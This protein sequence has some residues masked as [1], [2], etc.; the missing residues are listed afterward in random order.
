MVNLPFMKYRILASASNIVLPRNL[1]NIEI[2][3][4]DGLGLPFV[5]LYG[6]R[7]GAAEIEAYLLYL[8]RT[9]R[10]AGNDAKHLVLGFD[11]AN[12]QWTNQSTPFLR[13]C[14]VLIHLTTPL[15]YLD[16]KPLSHISRSQRSTSMRP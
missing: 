14:S 6:E 7:L 11:N 13:Y 12:V 3:T 16:S 9:L 5:F 15:T 1:Q 10:K 8:K 4:V 2:G